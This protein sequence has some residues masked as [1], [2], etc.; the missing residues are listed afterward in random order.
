MHL[1]F[2]DAA[3]AVFSGDLIKLGDELNKYEAMH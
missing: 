1:A 3:T 2:I